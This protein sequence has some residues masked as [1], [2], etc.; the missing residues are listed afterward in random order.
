MFDYVCFLFTHT[1]RQLSDCSLTLSRPTVHSHS[2]TVHTHKLSDRVHTHNLSDC[3]LTLS[4]CSRPGCSV[5]HSPLTPLALPLIYDRLAAAA[6]VVQVQPLECVADLALQSRSCPTLPS[7]PPPSDRLASRAR[8]ARRRGRPRS[9]ASPM[10]AQTRAAS[11]PCSAD[12]NA[13]L[14]CLHSL[15]LTFTSAFASAFAFAFSASFAS[16]AIVRPPTAFRSAR[17]AARS[18]AISAALAL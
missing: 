1:L 10:R 18:A 7:Q 14:L 5:V 11:P 4:V 8:T 12:S 3:S 6:L 16:L 2:P 9:T 13:P 15:H 17:A